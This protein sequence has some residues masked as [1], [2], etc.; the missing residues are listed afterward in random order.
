MHKILLV[1]DEEH[2]RS[3]MEEEL[4][5]EGYESVCMENG[6][7]RML[8]NYTNEKVAEKIHRLYVQIVKG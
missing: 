5:E 2:F 3:L 6:Y 1:D 7:R 4:S 8:E